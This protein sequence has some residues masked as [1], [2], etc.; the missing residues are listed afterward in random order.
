[1]RASH[2]SIR[3]HTLVRVRGHGLRVCASPVKLQ[4]KGVSEVSEWESA[5]ARVC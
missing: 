5:Q 2:L 4:T 3:V 1:M